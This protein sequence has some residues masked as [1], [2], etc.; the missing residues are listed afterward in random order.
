MR[1]NYKRLGDYIRDV[2]IRNTNLS[3]TTLLGVSVSKEFIISIA[4]TVGTD[5]RKYKVVRRGQF[6]YIP[7]TSRRGDKIGIALLEKEKLAL[8]SQAY[9]VFEVI[10]EHLLLPEYLMMW[11]RRPEFDRYARYMSYGSVREIFSWDDMCNVMLP[12][13]SIEKQREIVA[14][15]KAVQ[16]RIDINN[17]LIQKLEETAQAIYK[18]WFVDFEF[19]DENGNP[20]KSSGGEMI[21]SEL[22]EIPKGWK[23]KRIQ[24]IV[25]AIGG[26]TP[27]TDE[28]TY[29]KGGSI[30]WFSPTDLTK[31]NAVF[32]NNTEKRITKLGLQNSSAKIFPPYCLLMTS[33]ATIGKLTINLDKSCTNQGFIVMIPKGA[34]NAYFLYLW[35]KSRMEDIENLASGSTFLEVSKSDFKK[36][37]LIVPSDEAY[38]FFSNLVLS[39]FNYIQKKELENNI[40]VEISKMLLSKISV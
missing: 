26:G 34:I 11:F 2:D 1:S 38:I 9:T 27:S 8:V 31:N 37:E 7:D 25:D 21:D 14:E 29:W 36:L 30:L 23:I 12:I 35:A 39:L 3:V 10:D 6:T 19:P 24:E 13:P 40:T 15:Y 17:K 16:R 22:G 4:N 33:R 20:Y 5:F 32:S 28:S 18:Q